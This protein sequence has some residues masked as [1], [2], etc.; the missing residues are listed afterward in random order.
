MQV[1]PDHVVN[2]QLGVWVAGKLERLRAMRLQRMRTEYDARSYARRRPSRP[3]R[4]YSSASARRVA[5][6]TSAPRSAL[7]SAW[8]R[9]AAARSRLV[10]QADH[11]RFGKAP[12]NPT[13]LHRRL[14][15]LPGDL[16]SRYVFGHQRD[17][18]RPT[19]QYRGG[20]RRPRQA[21]Q[22]EA[23]TCGQDDR[24]ARAWPWRFLES[25]P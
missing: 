13:D 4:A 21:L 25:R 10:L 3:N 14:P 1:Q 11:A 23:I 7:S 15:N 2:L 12:A 9:S 24:G 6:S 19:G 5:A 16:H 17:R 8:S 20:T 22:F 18:P